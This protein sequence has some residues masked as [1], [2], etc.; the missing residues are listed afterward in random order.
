MEVW[1]T[2]E[3]KD[4]KKMVKLDI[5]CNMCGSTRE[6]KMHHK[7]SFKEIVKEKLREVAITE[8]CK[9]L[10]VEFYPSSFKA[11]GGI[12]LKNKSYIPLH[13]LNLFIKTNKKI[14]LKKAEESASEEYL[15][16]SNIETLC[17]KCLEYVKRGMVLCEVCQKEYHPLRND[18]CYK[19]MNK[20]NSYDNYLGLYELDN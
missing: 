8:L 14:L 11:V 3:Y 19:C 4:A 16:F 12:A 7:F 10:N 9:D 18:I 5:R 20:G 13:E 6:L 2:K 15:K 1:K 17:K